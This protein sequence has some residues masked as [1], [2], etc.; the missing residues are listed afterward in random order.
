MNRTVLVEGIVLLIASFV[1]IAEGVGLFMYRDA[2]TLFDPI[3]PGAYILILGTLLM[4]AGFAHL[5]VNSKN[6]DMDK[7]ATS[8]EMKKRMI[9]MIAVFVTYILLIYFI[10]YFLASIV[11][12]LLIFRVVGVKSW[13]ITIFSTLFLAVSFYICFVYFAR[14]IFPDTIFPIPLLSQYFPF[15]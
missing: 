14:L 12:F 7:A 3:G 5:I 9:N 10:G 1:A 6:I 8:R 4:V 15:L 2:R 11:F 13:P